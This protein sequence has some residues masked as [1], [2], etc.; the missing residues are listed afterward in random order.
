MSLLLRAP[1]IVTGHADLLD[2]WL[3]VD[4]AGT[5]VDTGT[6]VDAGTGSRTGQAPAA[7]AV[8][9]VDGT[10]VPGL[11]D[12]HCH[13]AVGHDFASAASEDVLRAAEH[14][15]A[16]GTT[17]LVASVATGTLPDTLAALYRL[18]PLV[19]D[20]V[21]AGIHLEGP[22]LSPA[23]RGAHRPDLLHAPTPAEV[24]A[25][26]D[27]AGDALRIVTIAPELPGALDTVA[28]LVA[29]GVVVAVGHTDASARQTRRAVEAG[30][31]LVTHLWN[32]MAPLHHREPGP[33]GVALTDDRL[34][35]ECIVDDHHLDDTVLALVQRAAPG[36][37]VLVSDAM[38]ATGCPDGDHEVAGSAVRVVGGVAR[39][40]DGSSLAGS[41]ITV[42][43]AARRLLA[44]GTPLTEVVAATACRPSRLLGR[45]VPLT[46]GS[47]ADVVVV[48]DDGTWR[49]LDPGAD[50]VAAP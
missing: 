11:V 33:I 19:E 23:R 1:R 47:P 43:D 21:L 26:T 46:P 2:A 27:A 16:A 44:T 17:A 37:M 30:A 20:G 9:H 40:A 3:L 22:W 50:R 4:D 13:G 39:T 18:R 42:A 10:L 6:V 25:C 29:T 28:R 48:D 31:T 45:P 35:L 36:R 32:G 7:D 5:V 8:R 49:P 41:T 14:H 24:R 34:L 38:A 15:R 12:L